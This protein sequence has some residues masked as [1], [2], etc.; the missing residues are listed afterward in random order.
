MLENVLNKI[1]LLHVNVLLLLGLALFGGIVG[2]RLFQKLRIPQVVGY[3]IIGILIGQSGLKIVDSSI[4]EALKPFNYF[5][6]G[7]IGFM[8]GGELKREVFKKYGKQLIYI[9][10]CEGITPFLFVTFFVGIIG[11]LLLGPSPFVWALA[12][13]L[14]AIASATDPATT[15][16]VLKEYKTR[17]PLTATILGI[18]ALDDGLALLL[19]AIASSV[20]GVLIG[21][22]QGSDLK[23]II[24]PFY[25]IGGAIGIGILFGFILTRV[26]RKYAEKERLLAFSVGTVLMVTGLSL[27]LH[28][29][30]LLATMTV[31]IVVAN[32]TAHKSKEIF[33]LVEGFTPP[34]YVLFFVLVGAKLQFS[35]MTFTVLFFVF[36]YLIFGMAGKAIGAS[37]GARLSKAPATVRKY[38]PF[39]LFSQAGVAIGLSILAAQ[40][41]PGEIGN[42]LV[43]IITAT[44]FITQLLGPSLTK[45]AVTKGGEVGLNI[46]EEDIMEKERAKDVMDKNPPIIPENTRLGGILKTF[47]EH[48]NLCYPVV[49]KDREIKGIITVEG[50]R[51]TF[52]EMDVEEIILANDLM[53][54]VVAKTKKDVLIKEV[55]DILNRY[56]IDYLPVVDDKNRLEGFIERKKLNKFISTR[57]I[58]LHKQADSLG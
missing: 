1:S 11:S 3:I 10:L 6:L 2:G 12:L 27:A 30:M 7:L 58:E 55:Q 28:L 37:V 33:N 52:L 8:V 17:G 36:L 57:I 15:A 9:L 16:S 39:S 19:F 48:D 51:Q 14:G 21:H 41:F 32:F 23:A 22:V 56:D 53:E 40:H 35:H 50:I 47:S 49:N 43:I 20:A 13:L 29:S 31:G 54:D 26:L 4:I 38:L 46:T 45:F 44:T 25:E 5:A 18:V 34:I 24:Y 42:T